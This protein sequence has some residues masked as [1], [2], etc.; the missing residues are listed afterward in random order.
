MRRA[1]LA[2]CSLL[3]ACEGLFG[4]DFDDLRPRPSPADAAT[5]A[6]ANRCPDGQKR[7][8]EACS[9][10]EDPTTGC[11][12]PSCTPCAGAEHGAS[13][14]D[15]GRCAI[16]CQAGYGRCA[17]G[18][19]KLPEDAL[20]AGIA[21]SCATA[22]TGALYGWGANEAGQL[23]DADPRI[24]TRPTLIGGLEGGVRSVGLGADFTLVSLASGRAASWGGN[25]LGQLG[26]GDTS[27]RISAGPLLAL[28]DNIAHVAAHA[29][30][31]CVVSR[32]GSVFCWGYNASGVVG[33]GSTAASI[34]EPTRVRMAE[35]VRRLGTGPSHACAVLVSG[36]LYCWGAADNGRLGTDASGPVSAPVRGAVTEPVDDVAVGTHH[37]CALLRDGSVRCWGQNDRGQLGTGDK[38]PRFAPFQTLP[39]TAGAVRLVAGESYTCA[40]LASGAL[41]CWGLVFEGLGVGHGDASEVTWPV[42]VDARGAVVAAAGGTHHVCARL[43]DDKIRCWGRNDSGQLGDGTSTGRLLPADVA[44]P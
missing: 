44:I 17:S 43:A 34:T 4:V 6:P 40:V 15:E 38:S 23:G 27:P 2:A 12:E 1:I 7:C 16:A 41:R 3:V 35:P 25:A 11:Q 32:V 18:C 5:D 13:T 39:P 36:A 29:W 8:G 19:C 26:T 24:R 20:A 10:E 9:P 28:V 14:C 30:H 31:G 42:T 21:H 33:I 37:T 22:R